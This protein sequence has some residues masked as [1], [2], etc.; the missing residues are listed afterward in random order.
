VKA[1]KRFGQHFLEPAWVAKVLSALS[2][3]AT[4]TFLEIGPGRGALTLPLAA[5]VH[6]VIAVEVDRDLAGD[7][8]RRAP[9]NVRIV[10]G[11]V[12]VMDLAG[13][14]AEAAPAAFRVAG[15]LPYNIS[16]PILARLFQLYDRGP[17]PV[18][19]TL[20]LQREVADR[21][22]AAAGTREYGVLSIAAQ[23]R[24]HV[25]RLL[26]LPPGAFRPAP[27]VHS[28]L[29]RLTFRTPDEAI[30]VPEDFD[31]LVRSVFGQRRKRLSNALKPFA[32]ATGR[33]AAGALDAAGVDPERR[34]GTLSVREFVALASALAR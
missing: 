16:S 11:D 9:G 32:D 8:R 29:I 18:D 17:R 13:A 5:R 14:L 10:E 19:L 2:P 22:G 4:D 15:N 6:Q 28:A 20:M 33:S 31:D 25:E 30:T 12:L 1:R 3:H 26:D 24:A 7:L 34:P 21:L 23:R 27:K